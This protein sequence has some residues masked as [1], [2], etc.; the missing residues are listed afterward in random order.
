MLKKF[1]W[2]LFLIVLIF[3]PIS[4]AQT[5]IDS[6]NFDNY[7]VYEEGI[8]IGA[9]R[10]LLTNQSLGKWNCSIPSSYP[11]CVYTYGSGG[12]AGSSANYSIRS[13]GYSTPDNYLNIWS[14]GGIG[15]T[16]NFYY[17]SLWWNHVNF[18]N[19]ISK[20]YTLS[21]DVKYDN[22]K[23]TP[24]TY[25]PSNHMGDVF[26]KVSKL[27]SADGIGF[28]AGYVNANTT[29]SGY[30]HANQ[31]RPFFDGALFQPS[32]DTD[33]YIMDG[34]YHSITMQFFNYTAYQKRE[35]IYIDGALCL[36]NYTVSFPSSNFDGIMIDT[37]NTYDMSIDNIK[38]YNGIIPPQ[39][40]SYFTVTSDLRYCPITSCLFF[41]DFNT[42]SSNYTHNLTSVH[43]TTPQ[44]KE[45]DYAEGL[46][47]IQDD[48]LF[49]N[50]S[51]WGTEG[52]NADMFNHIDSNTY[53]RVASVIQFKLNGTKPTPVSMN[54]EF[55][56]YRM[57]G[58][59]NNSLMAFHEQLYFA[60]ADDWTLSENA[61][62]INIYITNLGTS[63][64]LGTIVINNDESFFIK[65]EYD[66][67]SGMAYID[68]I[69]EQDNLE[70][71]NPQ[72]YIFSNQLVTN[73][74][75]QN[76]IVTRGDIQNPEDLF[77]GIDKIYWYGIASSSVPN[78]T[79]TYL[80]ETPL[81]ES[82]VKTDIGEQI[83]N[84]LSSY[85]IRTTLSKLLLWFIITVSLIVAVS[86][87][88][89]NE[90]AKA[91]VIIIV[92]FGW[93]TISW[94]FGLLPL[95]MFVAILFFFSIAAAYM[96]YQIFGSR[97]NG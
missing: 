50:S 89:M 84:A 47:I 81:N 35:S 16:G 72:S 33:C 90:T 66:Y 63:R 22:W 28:G 12:G 27:I 49:M 67:N 11:N 86:R 93:T 59:C 69:K 71:Y 9:S 54:S 3:L 18:T 79:Y 42:Y 77:V 5:L 30:A 17:T 92:A 70:G 26:L 65:T 4:I 57:R 2:V 20:E 94:Y 31:L 32:T 75:I 40:E 13:H 45:W 14:N 43:A 55:I 41:D 21:M 87:G 44:D 15:G 10:D 83:R 82:V 19:S 36:N 96:I 51:V 6:E 85:G 60:R 25:S 1:H 78:Y 76:F 61:T 68:I 73:C 88:E 95:T 29:S 24:S 62:A 39:S 7:S 23:K 80:N 37:A 52:R 56:V 48:Q 74:K 64:F 58:M 38:L 34:L 53:N 91:F 97:Q 8:T 46:A